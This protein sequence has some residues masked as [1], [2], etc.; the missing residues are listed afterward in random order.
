MGVIKSDDVFA[1]ADGNKIFCAGCGDPGEAKPMTED[2]FE[3]DVV[4]TCDVCGE[5]IL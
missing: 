5:R 2:D 3:D 1:W 4:V